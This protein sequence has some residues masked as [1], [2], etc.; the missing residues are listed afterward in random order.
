M[1][2]LTQLFTISNS[3]A[4]LFTRVSDLSL[5]DLS[6]LNLEYLALNFAHLLPKTSQPIK[7]KDWQKETRQVAYTK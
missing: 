2:L 5:S 4:T 3:S 7:V 1:E 6:C